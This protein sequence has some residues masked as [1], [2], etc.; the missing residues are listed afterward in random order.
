MHTRIHFSILFLTSS[1]FP[2][3]SATVD[4]LCKPWK[5]DCANLAGYAA[6]GSYGPSKHAAK[7]YKHFCAHRPVCRQPACQP[8]HYTP[9]KHARHHNHGTTSYGKYPVSGMNPNYYANPNP[10]AYTYNY[11]AA[12]GNPGAAAYPAPPA[13]Y[14]YPA[15]AP[16]Y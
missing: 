14:A 1:Y 13:P 7:W 11:A 3:Y 6:Y 5:C 10:A 12:G 8:A 15:P 4:A 16:Q 9:P 2:R